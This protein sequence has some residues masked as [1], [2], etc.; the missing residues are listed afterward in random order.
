MEEQPSISVITLL[1]GEKEFIPLIKHNFQSFEYPRD[2]LELIIID[3]GKVSLMDHFI[4]DERVLYLHL[5][6]TEIKEFI[7]KISFENDKDEILK[8]YQIKTKR[9]PNG[10]KRDYGVGMSSHE[11]FFHMDCDTSY[12]K[13]SIS[14]KLKFLKDKKVECVYNSS[15]LCHDLHSKDYSKLYKSESIYKIYECTLF[16]NKNYWS[17]GG[18]KWSDISCEGRFFSDNH[19]PQ[20]KMDNYYDTI[21]LLNIRN[22]QEYKP[23]GDVLL[24][25]NDFTLG[26]TDLQKCF[27]KSGL[28]NDDLMHPVIGK[29]NKA[30]VPSGLEDADP[31]VFFRSD[32]RYNHVYTMLVAG[33]TRPPI[34]FELVAQYTKNEGF[35]KN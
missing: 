33:D 20:R 7:E 21:K 25:N 9:L 32:I 5:N 15:V 14:R 23:V 2:K 3:D 18:F 16:H 30:K 29:G 19:G 8:N 35:K 27:P 13:S 28:Y 17:N 11:F 6:D 34:D 22:I 10:F 12:H 26:S 31:S 1:R 4:E 24:H